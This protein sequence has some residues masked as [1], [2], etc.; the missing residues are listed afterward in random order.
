MD[1]STLK[2]IAYHTNILRCR[3]N[4]LVDRNTKAYLETVIRRTYDKENARHTILQNYDEAGYEFIAVVPKAV[5]LLLRV[6]AET[7]SVQLILAVAPGGSVGG[8][9]FSSLAVQFAQ[10]FFSPEQVMQTRITEMTIDPEPVNVVTA[11]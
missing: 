1:M 10:F 3:R 6:T 11:Q 4:L 7:C 5:T 2:G 8:R 9:E